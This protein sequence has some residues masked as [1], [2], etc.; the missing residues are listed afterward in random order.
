MRVETLNA[1]LTPDERKTVARFTR[2]LQI[3]IF[4]LVM[5]AT[6]FLVVVLVVPAPERLN[7]TL[8]WPGVGF[9]VLQLVLAAVVP[10]IILRKQRQAAVSGP[11]P[12]SEV[13]SLVAGIQVRRIIA[14]AL[15]EGAAFFNLVAYMQ[16]R[17]VVSLAMAGAL[18][19]GLVTLIPLRSL[20]EQWVETEVRTIRELRQLE[21]A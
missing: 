10:Q 17:Q 20:V 5:G 7:E 2:L 9:G 1:M 21:G 4:S 15:L 6:A 16:G 19:A 13:G 18:I 3:I 11:T 8:V 12:I 14:G